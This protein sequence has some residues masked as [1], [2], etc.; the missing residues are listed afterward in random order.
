MECYGC[1]VKKDMTIL[2]QSPYWKEDCLSDEPIQP[3]FVIECQSDTDQSDFRNVVV[4]H[5][6]YH[7]LEPDMWIS[8]SMYKALNPKIP[9]QQVPQTKVI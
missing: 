9:F 1:G 7:K 8:E 2:E 6:C 4:C 5:E 3:L